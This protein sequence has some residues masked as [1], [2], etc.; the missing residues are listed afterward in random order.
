MDKQKLIEYINKG[1]SIRQIAKKENRGYSSIR[2]WLKKHSLKTEYLKAEKDKLVEELKNAVKNSLSLSEVC[3]ELNRPTSG[4]G[5]QILRA[6]IKEHNIDISHFNTQNYMKNI[7]KLSA[8]EILVY[9]RNKGRREKT[10]RLKKAMMEKGTDFSKCT[11]C[12]QTDD[13]NCKRLVLQ[14]DHI[15]G[16]R[17]NNVI[18]NLRVICPNC[19]SQT[20]TYCK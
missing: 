16:N 5:Y 10:S 18:N 2:Y 15:D 20:E 14:I 11:L 6:L 12:P 9:D 19:H 8:D 4:N 3:R 1:N 17:V 7:V 13:W